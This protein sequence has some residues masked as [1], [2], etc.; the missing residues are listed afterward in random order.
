MLC[1]IRCSH[2]A[3]L[4]HLVT[5]LEPAPGRHQ[6]LLER[7]LGAALGQH[8]PAGAQEL[9]PVALDDRL[10]R[11]LVPVAGQRDEPGVGLRAQEDERW[12]RH[13]GTPVTRRGPLT[14]R[15]APG[16]AVQP[17]GSG[18]SSRPCSAASRTAGSCSR[19]RSNSAGV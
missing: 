15:S 7:V 17:V 2:G 10:E 14:L 19:L 11:P 3:Q 6:G 16:E 1:A 13:H 12:R 18:S 8:A 9:A 4:A 5:A